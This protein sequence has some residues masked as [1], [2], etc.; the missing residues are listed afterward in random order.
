MDIKTHRYLGSSFGIDVPAFPPASLQQYN[1]W[2]NG[3]FSE[4]SSAPS[5]SL[6][7]KFVGVLREGDRGA[8]ELG[9]CPI[10]AY[11]EQYT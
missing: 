6:V 11:N 1:F 2:S 8:D 3:L 7:R 4:S 5:L 10:L 9:M